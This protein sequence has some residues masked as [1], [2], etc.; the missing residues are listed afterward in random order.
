M[1]NRRIILL[2][3]IVLCF[4]TIILAQNIDKIIAQHIEAHGGATKWKQVEAMKI[5]GRFIAFSIEKEFMAIKTKNGE[6]YS[7]LYL[8]KFAVKEAFDGKEGWTIDP[9]QEIDFPRRL[10]TAEKN[11]FNQKAEFFTPFFNYKEKG[12]KVELI[13]KETL[14][15]NEVYKI[16][17]TRSN[18]YIETWYLNTKTYLEFKCESQWVD[19]A[20]QLPC[21]TYFD[22]FQKVDG[23]TIPFYVEQTFGQRNRILTIEKV[24]LNTKLD[25]SLLN[26]PRSK[27]IGKLDFLQ[28]RWGVIFEV[29]SSRGAWYRMD[30]VVS[31]IEFAAT[32]MLE[33]KISYDRILPIAKIINYTYSMSTKKYRL[34]VFNDFTSSIDVFEGEFIDN[35]LVLDNT[36][37]S[38]G[39]VNAE[40]RTFTQITISEIL[41]NTFVIEVKESNDNGETWNPSDK[42]SYSRIK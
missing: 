26:M 2:I 28:G 9:W 16:K 30:S 36:K 20:W 39:E 10:N 22:D 14:E 1:K 33:E 42:F 4:P 27:E 8:G 32:N 5:T 31:T 40:T 23:L 38:Y 34:S 13:G 35:T 15:G 3:I 29:W 12:H 17:L 41:T 6:Y 7:D 37:I 21:E 24:E 19:F 18:G 11:V 25:K